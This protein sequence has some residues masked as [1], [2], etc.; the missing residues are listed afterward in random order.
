MTRDNPRVTFEER[1]NSVDR[2]ATI[3]I[4]YARADR[5]RL[6]RVLV[7]L[8]F[9]R[10]W[11]ATLISAIAIPLSAIPAFWFMEMLGFSLNGVTLLALSLWA[12]GSSMTLIVESRT[13]SGTCHGQGAPIRPRSTP[14][15][16]RL[17]VV[18]TTF[19]I[20]AVFLPSA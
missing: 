10:D 12:G 15:R 7:V 16:D 14:P 5:G 17:P 1:F 2:P 6:A 8:I 13:S 20:V 18:A 9:L 4:R 11:R 19:S 3:Q